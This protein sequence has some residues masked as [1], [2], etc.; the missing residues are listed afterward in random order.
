MLNN[1]REGL[2]GPLL[3]FQVCKTGGLGEIYLS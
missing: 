2:F 3:V 1:S